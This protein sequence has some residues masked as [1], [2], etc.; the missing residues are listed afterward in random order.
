M[1]DEEKL[2]PLPNQ[3]PSF[4]LRA[5]DN[6]IAVVGCVRNEYIG[7]RSSYNGDY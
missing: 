1:L 2:L 7:H 4:G 3:V 5:N 6:A